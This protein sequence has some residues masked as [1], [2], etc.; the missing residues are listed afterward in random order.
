MSVEGKVEALNQAVSQMLE[1]FAKEKL[2]LVEIQVC[3]ISFGGTAQIQ[4]PLQS[5]T[6]AH[7]SWQDMKT[8]PGTPM[9][10]AMCLA[11]DLIED[12]DQFPSR[13]YRPIIVLIS[14]GLPKD[15]W[16]AGLKRLTQESRAQKADR[17]AMAVGNDAD[18]AM[19]QQYV[20]DPSKPVFHPE[21]AG[22]IFEFIDWLPMSITARTRREDADELPEEDDP[23]SVIT[24]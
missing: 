3:I 9:G 24:P 12:H 10:A 5:A 4:M 23:F 14:D 20:N 18:E 2:A 8:K 19:L 6:D 13:A 15:D 16:R 11:A 7:S 21:D 1:S 17:L 22:R